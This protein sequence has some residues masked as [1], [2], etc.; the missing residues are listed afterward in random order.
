MIEITTLTKTG[1]PLTKRISLAS[2]GTLHSNGSACVMSAGSA[3]RAQFDDLAS[4]AGFIARLAPHEAIALGA[5]RDDLPDRVKITTKSA[6]NGTHHRPD[7]I[8]R[9]A[10]HIIY[11]PGQPALALID[12]DTKGMPDHVR[13]NIHAI[14]GYWAALLSVLPELATIGRV[15]RRST[16][17]GIFRTDTNQRLPGSDGNHVYVV[18]TDGTDTKRFLHRLHERCWLQGFGWL[19]LGTAGQLL[20]RSLVDRMVYAPERLVFEGAPV[21][22]PPLAQDQASREPR[23]IAGTLIDSRVLCPDLSLVEQSKLR[24]LKD[25]EAH[26]MAPDVDK[27]RGHY[28]KRFAERT[29]CTLQVV[30]DMAERQHKG[31]LL[32]SVVLPFDTGEL[33]GKT[34]RDVLADPDRFIGETLADPLEGEEY[35]RCKAKIMQRADGTLWVNSFAHGRTTYD[36]KHDATTIET[37]LRKGEPGE[38][39][40]KFVRLLL[41]ADLAPEEEQRLRDLACGLSHTR[42]RPL[43]AKIKAARQQQEQQ[44]AQAER[45]RRAA[46]RTDPRPQVPAPSPDAPWL[47][48]MQVLNEVLGASREPEPPMRDIDGV[49]TEVRVRRIPDMHALTSL[50]ANQEETE[51]TRLPPPSQPALTRL[52]EMELAELIERHIEYVDEKT[53]RLVHLRTSFVQHYLKRSDD[54]LPVVAAIATLPIVLAD[55]SLLAGSGLDRDR[56]IVFR[57]PEEL[58][59]HPAYARAMRRR[60]QSARRSISSP[61]NGWSMWLPTSPANASSSP[62]R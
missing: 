18:L 30:R 50:G 28:I 37:A 26:R 59:V 15:V 57:V 1:G 43:A 5:L 3:Q 32:P 47:P 40:D 42:S 29:G 11:R 33:R 58:R 6:L 19:M 60:Q 39:A 10:D 16:S 21:L 23:V 52:N 53:G 49:V 45:E 24:A 35:G 48:Q 20:D 54:A 25:G 36:L 31:V 12:I 8:A 4:F 44:R 22:S 38:A 14:G 56:G 9:S 46:E 13:D 34:V 62:Q 51:D 61:R 7:L 27:A 55:G 41:A 17:A 2:D